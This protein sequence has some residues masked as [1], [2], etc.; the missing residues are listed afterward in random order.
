[1]AQTDVRDLLLR[2]QRVVVSW[3][4]LGVNI[5]CHKL[6]VGGEIHQEV[7]VGGQA[8]DVVDDEHEDDND[9]TLPGYCILTNMP[10]VSSE[11]SLCLLPKPPTWQSWDHNE[12]SPEDDKDNDNDDDDAN[13]EKSKGY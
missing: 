10:A 7:D 11:Q 5:A 12:H 4:K 3:N 8:L 13:D 6:R 9:V 2:E 1:M